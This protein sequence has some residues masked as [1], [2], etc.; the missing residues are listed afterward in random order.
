MPYCNGVSPS[1]GSELSSNDLLQAVIYASSACADRVKYTYDRNGNRTSRKN[2]VATGGND[3]LYRYDELDRLKNLARGTLTGGAAPIV[4][5]QAGEAWKL[6]ATGNWNGYASLDL[7]DSTNTVEQNRSA[8]Q[9]NEITAITAEVGLVW[10]QP[11]YDRAG[12]MI[13]L[14]QPKVPTEGYAATYDAWNRLVKLEDGATTVATYGYDALT[15]RITIDNGTNVRRTYFSKLWQALEERLDASTLPDRQF[16]WGLRYIDDLV[17][18]DRTT[19]GTLDERLYALQDANWN[20]TAIVDETGVIK[21]RYRYSAYGAPT[22]LN[23]DF[24]MKMPNESEFDWET[25]YC[26]YCYDSI[27]GIYKVRYRDLLSLL[28][29]WLT[30]DPIGYQGLS[31]NLYEYLLA[32]PTDNTDP[33]GLRG[34]PLVQPVRPIA[35]PQPLSPIGRFPV[36]SS[37]RLRRGWPAPEP[38]IIPK[39]QLEQPWPDPFGVPLRLSPYPNLPLAIMPDVGLAPIPAR[40]MGPPPIRFAGKN[41]GKCSWWEWQFYQEG[42]HAYCD[43][44]EPNT[45]NSIH[46]CIDKPPLGLDPACQ[47]IHRRIYNA[48]KCLQFRIT[49]QERCYDWL[50]AGKHLDEIKKAVTRA[51]DCHTKAI[52]CKCIIK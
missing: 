42:I 7:V 45:C 22:F 12:N 18:R 35:R 44:P 51:V 47:Q 14:P 38:I 52:K 23:P 21:E 31:L 30:K 24:S 40:V 20:V 16:V 13:S 27:I 34:L 9:A 36:D 6:D 37:N 5:P 10:A 28:G 32:T 33:F 8:N 49:I 3:E 48:L 11:L 4:S 26:S 25:L 46:C 15:R 39:L 2:A 1:D 19:I 29:R 43:T 41:M 50:N 17:L